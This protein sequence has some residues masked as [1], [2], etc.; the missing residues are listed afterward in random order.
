MHTI[1]M[2]IQGREIGGAQPCFVIAE[3]GV[4]H[5]GSRELARR[6]IDVAAEAGADCV[7]F[8]TF[9]AQRLV[10]ASAPKASYQVRTTGGQESQYEMLRRLE[11]SEE[12]HRELIAHARRRGICF[13]STPFDE[14]SA[15]FLDSLGVPAFKIP[16]GELTNLPFLAHVARKHKPMIVSLGMASLGETEAAVE[17]I[18]RAGNRQLVLLQC[19]SNYPADPADVN[20]RAMQTVQTAFGVPVGYS[21]HTE[22]LEA[23]LAAVALGACVVEKHF[24]LDRTL[25]GPDH[26]ASIEPAELQQLVR[27]IRIVEAA[28]GS[29]RKQPVASEA[30]TAAVARK[31]LVAAC[32]LPAGTVLS[33]RLVAARR[34]GT[35][36]PPAMLPYVLGRVLRCPVAAGTPL[37]LEMLECVRLAS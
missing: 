10:T 14:Q 19:V 32:D 24:T 6:L 7:K 16:S 35:G 20:L 27:S 12:D 29:G 18:E 5:N 21:D 1:P 23:A 28:L 33:E 37:E 11:L 30:D 34:P 22:G 25:S 8:Q 15:D 13:L 36:L 9:S 4:N 17:A 2:S 3:A 31:S 26:A